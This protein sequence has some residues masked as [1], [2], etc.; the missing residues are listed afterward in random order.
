MNIV[1][2][3]PAPLG[4]SLLVFPILAALRAKYINS[5][6]TFLGSPAVLPLAKAWGIADETINPA[7]V[8]WHEIVSLAG[9]RS[10]TLRELLVKSDLVICWLDDSDGWVKKSLRAIGVKQ[11]IIAPEREAFND[12]K[13]IVE[14]LAEPLDLRP[15]GTGFVAPSTGRNKGF[16]SY[17]PPI[18]IHPGCSEEGR[19]WPAASFAALINQLLRLQHPVLLLAGPSEVEVLKEVR[20]RLLSP[21]QAGLLSVLQN[22]PLLEVA[23]RLQQCRSFL[24]NDSGISHLAGMLGIPTLVLFGPSN[25]LTKHPVGPFVET[26]YAQPMKRLPVEKVLKSILRMSQ[27]Q[28]V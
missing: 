8:Q 19:R 15:L 21:P 10:P 6:I 11:F 26:L 1:A 23:Q 12:S 28:E 27:F 14:Q 5:H 22:A 7:D 13:H 16:C 2:I 17:N 3:R 20:R 4:D 18:A 9:I 24:G 25:P